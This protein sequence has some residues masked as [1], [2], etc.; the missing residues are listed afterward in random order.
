VSRWTRRLLV[1]AIA[2]LVPALAGCEAGLNA[3]TLQFHPASNGYSTTFNGITIDNVF[4][5]GPALN[6]TLPAGG[7]AGVFLSLLAQNN[8][9][10]VSVGAPGY[11]LRASLTSGPVT[12]I[13][14]NL[15]DLSGPTPQI[16]LNGLTGP[17]NAGQTVKLTLNFANAGSVTFPV[18]VVPAAYDYATYSPPPTPTPTPSPTA[19]GK[20]KHKK[21][22][23][24]S[25]TGTA[26]PSPS[27]TS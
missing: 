22:A 18:P 14:N 26:S 3:P 1:G 12:L 15:V 27:A 16:V 11:A 19:S 10:L 20:H 2:I 5:L 23:G 13:A 25:P 17:L 7:Q 24:T 21:G 4:V 8:D 6:S 9:R